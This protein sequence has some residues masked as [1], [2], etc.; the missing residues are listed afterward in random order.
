MTN[1]NHV[2]ANHPTHYLIYLYTFLFWSN[3]LLDIIAKFIPS[4]DKDCATNSTK[5]FENGTILCIR[6]SVRR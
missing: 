3:D 1:V 2:H 4:I 5:Y 6:F